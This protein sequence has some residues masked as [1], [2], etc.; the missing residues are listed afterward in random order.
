MELKP[1]I[2]DD[3]D[4]THIKSIVVSDFL[5]NKVK[6]DSNQGKTLYNLSKPMMWKI[7]D[8]PPSEGHQSDSDSHR[9]K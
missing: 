3:I 7:H 9:R 6:L 5:E 8:E 1:Q 4:R 2:L